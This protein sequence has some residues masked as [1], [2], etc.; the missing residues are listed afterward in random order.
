MC[1]VFGTAFFSFFDAVFDAVFDATFFKS[2]KNEEFE[3]NRVQ[4][5]SC[6]ASFVKRKRVSIRVR[7]VP[8][9]Y[10]YRV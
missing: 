2:G 8:I 9:M 3:K 7:L 5:V 6:R 10:V 4:I 1:D